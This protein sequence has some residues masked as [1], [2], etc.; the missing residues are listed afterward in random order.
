MAA[1]AARSA[2]SAFGW[3]MLALVVAFFV[4][5]GIAYLLLHDAFS[6]MKM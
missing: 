3:V 2:I 1:G 6:Y 5:A 4:I